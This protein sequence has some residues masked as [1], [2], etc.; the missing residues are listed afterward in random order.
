M[1]EIKPGRYKHFKGGVYQVLGIA[2]QSE[3]LEELVIYQNLEKK[4]LWA[5]PKHIFLQKVIVNGKEAPR[6]KYIEKN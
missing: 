4:C 1:E 3:T 6:F 2:K 5:R